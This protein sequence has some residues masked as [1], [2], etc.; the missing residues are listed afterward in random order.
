MG[1]EIDTTEVPY[2]LLPWEVEAWLRMDIML[3]KYLIE[4]Q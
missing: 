2:A 1:Q 4:V 3:K